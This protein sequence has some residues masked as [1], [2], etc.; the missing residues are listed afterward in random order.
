MLDVNKDNFEQEVLQE[1]GLVLVD[2]WSPQCGPCKQLLPDLL[3]LAK[4]YDG[5]AKFCK[6]NTA[7]NRRLAIGQKVL[8]LPTVIIYEG[9]VKAAELSK[10]FSVGDIESKLVELMGRR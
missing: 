1:Q 2:F 7:E 6:L 10:E 5:K 9:G 4:K 3:E 8:G